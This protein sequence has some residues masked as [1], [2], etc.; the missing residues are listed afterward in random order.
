LLIDDVMGRM[1][2]AVVDGL[3]G[4]LRERQLPFDSEFS[5]RP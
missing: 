2:K 5:H 4:R 1:T 3:A